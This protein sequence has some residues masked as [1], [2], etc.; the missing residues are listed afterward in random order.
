MTRSVMHKCI[1]LF[2]GH[3]AFSQKTDTDIIGLAGFSFGDPDHPAENPVLPDHKVVLDLS[4]DIHHFWIELDPDN[5]AVS[6]RRCLAAVYLD[7]AITRL[8]YG[9]LEGA[10]ADCDQIIRLTPN[11]TTFYK[12]CGIM[13]QGIGNT[14]PA[15]AYFRR[16]LELQPNAEDREE[17]EGWIAEL[18]AQNSER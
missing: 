5:T 10:S 8:E 3:I 18:E 9:D 13:H 16:Y 14:Q 2:I 7:R 1:D 6:C 12:P 17:V 11:L 15:L 4:T